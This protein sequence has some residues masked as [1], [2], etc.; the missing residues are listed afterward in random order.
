MG[1]VHVSTDDNISPLTVSFQDRINHR[2]RTSPGNRNM[3][4]PTS[5]DQL[6]QS[7][8]RIAPVST[9]TFTFS[10]P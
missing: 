6:N 8:G 4:A 9:S 7:M 10:S 2:V 3:K 5:L 1:L